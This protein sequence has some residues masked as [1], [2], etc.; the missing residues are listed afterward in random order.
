M[1]NEIQKIKNLIPNL[2]EKDASLA[3]KFLEQRD[4][5]SLKDIIDSAIYK[6][7]QIHPKELEI[8]YQIGKL[9][10]LKVNV[11]TYIS[12]LDYTPDEIF[13]E[14]EDVILK[15]DDCFI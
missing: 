4:F 8:K 7:K 3:F 11:D 1:E 2:C 9:E 15:E 10:D 5:L 13:N 12:N 14:Y 6:V